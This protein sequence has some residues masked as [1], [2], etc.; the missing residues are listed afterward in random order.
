MFLMFAYSF[1]NMY[2]SEKNEFFLQ[3]HRTEY[4]KTDPSYQ[5][6]LEKLPPRTNHNSRTLSGLIKEIDADIQ[7][8][9]LCPVPSTTKLAPE[10]ILFNLF[11]FS[12]FP[13]LIIF[14]IMLKQEYSHEK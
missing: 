4:H 14:L 2:H 3:F 12:F 8:S 6:C 5:N 10:K 11:V 1:S 9:Q 13:G 7:E